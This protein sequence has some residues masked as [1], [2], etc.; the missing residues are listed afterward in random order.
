MWSPPPLTRVCPCER[1]ARALVPDPPE[2]VC[3]QFPAL[4]LRTVRTR[5]I[6]L[7]NE[8]VVTARWSTAVR[9]WPR[10]HCR[11]LAPD[12]WAGDVRAPGVALQVA[13]SAGVLAAHARAPLHVSVYADCW[14][15]YHDQLLILIDNIEP[16]VLDV[17]VEAVGAP[18]QLAISAPPAPS[19]DDIPTM[20]MSASDARR[21]LRAR[22]TSRAPL[23]VH[24]YTAA[25]YEYPQDELPFR[26]YIRY[27]DVPPRSCSCVTAFQAELAGESSDS[28]SFVEVETGFDIYLAPDCGP[29]T[30]GY[31]SVTPEVCTLPPGHCAE[32]ELALAAPQHDAERAP[33]V[34][35]LLRLQP[36]QYA[37]PSWWRPEPPPQRVRL[38]QV[39]RAG[40][41]R[42][43][44]RELR[45]RLCALDLPYGDVLRVRKRF[46]VMNVGSGVLELGAE[47]EAPWCVVRE[48]TAAAPD[49]LPRR[50]L[51]RGPCGA[52]CGCQLRLSARHRADPLRL[53]PTS[54]IEM[55]VEV[56]VNTSQVWPAAAA[57]SAGPCQAPVY[58]PRSVT[59]TPLHIFD[60]DNVLK[61][62]QLVLDLEFPILCVQPAVIDFGVVADG[63]TRKMYFSVSHTS[64]T[65]TLDIATQWVGGREFRIWPP[66]LRIAPGC[67]AN[68]YLQ[69]TA[70][71]RAAPSEGCAHVFVCCGAGQALKA[72]DSQPGQ[73]G[74]AGQPGQVGWT[75]QPEQAAKA[76]EA[77]CLALGQ[78]MARAAWC[79][80]AVS[81][82]AAPARD[83]KFHQT[84]HDHTDDACLLPPNAAL[85][86]T[87]S[88]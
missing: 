9:R 58:P 29:Q 81:V 4:P 60:D 44:C 35:L 52:G 67:S 22:N 21:V 42:V 72:R 47:T 32:W 38:R 19:L 24:A 88:L 12:Q 78:E 3:L 36:L 55:C 7:R 73:V 23:L 54:C 28:C 63:D 59:A 1:C 31:Y 41:L 46:H 27:Y 80:A 79:R 74:H 14:G 2:P 18:L 17:W 49:E 86:A 75:G 68:V 87:H 34:D 15:L 85:Y 6:H 82:R 10:Q 83:H 8:S 70:I 25:S 50:A 62:V 13:P 53:E 56:A 40:S 20:W 57:A 84:Q 77:A 45:V 30:D 37:G 43:S 51:S 71:W 76:P 39:E 61:T 11:S 26:L 48:H 5:T 69:Y 64:T 65:M 16:I 33:D 66:F